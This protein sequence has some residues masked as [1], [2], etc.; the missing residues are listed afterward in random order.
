MEQIRIVYKRNFYK[1]IDFQKYK[2][3][4]SKPIIGWENQF[5]K[6]ERNV[7][8]AF[9]DKSTRIFPEKRLFDE[10]QKTKLWNQG[11]LQLTII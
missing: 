11:F 4:V 5:L 10:D 1:Q 2:N 6:R 8:V 9:V 7:D 3:E